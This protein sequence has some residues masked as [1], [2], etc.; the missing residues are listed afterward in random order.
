MARVA[1]VTGGTRG[2]GAAISETLLKSGY[3]VAAIY[4]GNDVAAKAFRAK[5]CA[6]VYRWGAGDLEACA[7]GIREVEAAVGPVDVLV[8]NAGIVRDSALH[9]MTR[10]QWDEVIANGSQRAFNMCRPVIEGMRKR[11]F[12]R[13]INISSIDGQ[14]GQ[15]GQTNHSAAKAGD[16]GFTRALALESTRSGITVNAICP[17]YIHTEML[18]PVPPEV[19]ETSILRLI[20]VGRPGEPDDI[21]RAVVFLAADKASFITGSTLS[22]DGGQYMS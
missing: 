2:I 1:L 12:G 14:K 10:A 18:D 9:K 8:N 11:K 17:G 16:L 13:I 21:A 6:A 4:A 20:P 5:T 15:F 3:C 7:T 22:I 19:M